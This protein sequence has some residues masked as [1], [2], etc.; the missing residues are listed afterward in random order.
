MVPRWISLSVAAVVLVGLILLPAPRGGAA[1]AT[2][3]ALVAR[4]ARVLLD[5]QEEAGNL[6]RAIALL[7]RALANGE[8]ADLL[9]L[10]AE[11]YH[12]KRHGISEKGQALEMLERSIQVADKAISLDGMIP[13]ARYWRGLSLLAKANLARNLSSLAMVRSAIQDMEWVVRKD[14]GYDDAGAYRA[15]GKIYSDSPSWFLGDRKKAIASL[16]KAR[17]RAG[18]SFLNRLYLAEA[19]IADGRGDDAA[20]ELQWILRAQPRPNTAREDRG[21]QEKAGKLLEGVRSR[22]Q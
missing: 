18:G 12:S 22:L 10:L 5:T 16:E 4:E 9:A 1:Q 13:A 3:G 2:D 21:Y 19:Y 7:E 17:D 20:R 6:D 14:E 8:Q 11:G 15:L